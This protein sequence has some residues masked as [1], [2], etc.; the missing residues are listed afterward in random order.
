MTHSFDGISNGDFEMPR[1]SSRA[2]WSRDLFTGL[3]TR[4]DI[5][6]KRTRQ[7]SR[8]TSVDFRTGTRYSRT[9]SGQLWKKLPI[10]GINIRRR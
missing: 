9:A 6:R 8:F 10:R 5:P 2:V 4:T 7:G 1:K 3:V